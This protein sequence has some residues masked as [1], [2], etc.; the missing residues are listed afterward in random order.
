MD[1]TVIPSVNEAR[2]DDLV[3]KT[4]IVIDVLRATSTMLTALA[5]GCDAIYPVETVLQAKHLLLEQQDWL[6]GGERYCKKSRVLI[7]ATPHLSI[8]MTKLL[9]KRLFL[10]PPTVHVLSRKLTDPVP[11][12]SLH[13]LT[14][15]PAP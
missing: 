6:T 8:W 3:N 12:L 1:I 10:R 4:V 9:V 13:C 7:L 2:S 15:E 11:Y 5:H 14:A